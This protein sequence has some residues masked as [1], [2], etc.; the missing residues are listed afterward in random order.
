MAQLNRFEMPGTVLQGERN[1]ILYRYA[2]SLWAQ[3]YDEVAL[4]L[5]LMEANAA[6]CSPPLPEREVAGIAAH[7]TSDLPQGL[8]PEYEAK[9][10]ERRDE[11][12]KVT[13]ET[14]PFDHVNFNDRELSRV[15][16]DMYRDRLRYVPEAHGFYAYDGTRWL[17]NKQGGDGKAEMYMKEFVDRLLRHAVDI[18]D[19]DK[20]DKCMKAAAKYNAHRSRAS[21]LEDCKGELCETIT[22]FDADTNLLNVK[23]GTLELRPFK[24]R[25][26]RAEDLI[27][28]VA[29]C[30][31]DEDANARDWE[32]FLK[33][34]FEGVEEVKGFLQARMSMALAGDNGLECF[35][36]LYGE[37]R[38]GKSTFTETIK[39]VFGEYATTAQPV[40]FAKG[41]RDSQA[42]SPDYAA[43]RGS[44]FV[45]CPEPNE[46]MTLSADFIK[47]VT[48][49][50]T[51]TAR[52]LRGEL[53]TFR[54]CFVLAFNTNYLMPTNDNTLFT[55]GRVVVAKFPNV[56]P[57]GERD[58]D[59]KE[60]LFSEESKS[61]VLNWLLRGLRVQDEFDPPI[62]QEC[63]N[64][65]AK[66]ASDSDRIGLF[67]ADNCK[68]GSDLM[69]SGRDL[70]GAYRGWCEDNGFYPLNATKFYN[71]LQRRGFG[72]VKRT[73]LR[74]RG[75]VRNVYKGLRL[76][77]AAERRG[78]MGGD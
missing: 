62:P 28:K 27:T 49:K 20:R 69:E 50:D 40:T 8:S 59:L 10:S 76:L 39:A 4:E 68:R 51:I 13:G 53:F 23:N 14:S 61:A 47:Q 78:G 29:G 22:A 67:I 72:Y 77:S 26:H 11:T 3:S 71:Q 60:R 2:C 52:H 35:Y 9:R 30:G 19:D 21:L 66:Y 43:L 31:Y 56:V 44:R 24:F 55:S 36:I 75:Q 37:P 57:E 6:H 42:A 38:T 17:T 63:R 70:F 32:A 15:F 54:P 33:R 48:G 5:E 1:D 7:V 41:R 64:E 58:K 12:A 16:A 25:G 34:T 18:K 46:D 74:G 65:V 45:V 73:T